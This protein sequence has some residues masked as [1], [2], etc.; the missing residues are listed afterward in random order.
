MHEGRTSASGGEDE[1]C[2][3][4][5]IVCVQAFIGTVFNVLSTIMSMLMGSCAKLAGG[6]EATNYLHLVVCS[7]C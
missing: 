6:P 7:E 5:S 4:F 2:I 3:N 1:G